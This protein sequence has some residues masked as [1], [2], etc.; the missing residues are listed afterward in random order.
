MPA[1]TPPGEGAYLFKTIAQI[2]N[3][4]AQGPLLYAAAGNKEVSAEYGRTA[5]IYALR[6]FPDGQTCALRESIIAQED[7]TAVATAALRTLENI[8]KTAP[9]TTAKVDAPVTV[10]VAPLQK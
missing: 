4:A 7:N 8:R 1:A 6:N 3:A 10:P 5:A 2:D 9:E